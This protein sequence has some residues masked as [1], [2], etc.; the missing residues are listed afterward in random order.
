MDS[1][2][3]KCPIC[4]ETIQNKNY[5]V[6]NCNHK[7]C[8]NC[9]LRLNR[10]SNS[11]PLCRANLT[12]FPIAESINNQNDNIVY[13]NHFYRQIIEESESSINANDT[14]YES[15]R[16]IIQNLLSI[17]RVI[18]L[19]YPRDHSDDETT[20][21]VLDDYDSSSDGEEYYYENPEI[22][23]E[24]TPINNFISG[25]NFDLLFNKF[26]E[27]RSE[28][29]GNL[30]ISPIWDYLNNTQKT[31]IFDSITNDWDEAKLICIFPDIY[32]DNIRLRNK[33]N[34]MTIRVLKIII[35]NFDQ[36]YSDCLEK[37]DYINKIL[38]F[39]PNQIPSI[40]V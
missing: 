30:L 35:K 19:D 39:L 33:L 14:S 17:I 31:E 15:F 13:T 16:Y 21:E 38:Q 22:E 4:Y 6:T 34:Q 7:F 28:A 9:I 12:N 29:M 32:V 26:Q 3:E 5:I 25:N 2:N 1:S 18:G 11:C 23:N 40:L 27:N 24:N 36:D 20:E 10:S 8:S 37:E